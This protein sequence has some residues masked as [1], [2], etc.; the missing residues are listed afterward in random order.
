MSENSELETKARLFDK[1]RYWSG[2]FTGVFIGCFIITA[3]LVFAVRI[4]GLTVALDPEKLAGAAQVRVA[5]E[6]KRS[7]PQVL[8]GI[9]QEL[10]AQINANLS[11]LD[12]LN[13]S[14]GKTQV[15][16]PEEAVSAIKTE[17]NRIIEEAV[18]N[19]LNHYDTRPYEAKLGK[20]TYEMF[21]TM[22]RQEVIGKTYV[23]RAAQWFSLPIKIVG[24]SKAPSI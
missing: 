2:V 18:I 20:N 3:L 1:D 4:R 11:G 19:T 21:D 15:K 23:L 17:F 10:P 6:A 24:S 13:I 5:A 9:K 16:L 22:L 14:I 12:E 8:E 7:L